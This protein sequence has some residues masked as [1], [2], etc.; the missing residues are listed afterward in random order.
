[1][2]DHR[3]TSASDARHLGSFGAAA[4]GV[5][6]RESAGQLLGAAALLIVPVLLYFLVEPS[7]Q[8]AAASAIL[9]ALA[10]LVP[11]PLLLRRERGAHTHASASRHGHP[12]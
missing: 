9:G 2:A 5:V 4:E 11:A 12:R 10:Y 7:L 6:H 1:M 3:Q 8:D